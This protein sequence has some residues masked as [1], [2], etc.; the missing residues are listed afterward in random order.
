MRMVS[1]KSSLITLIFLLTITNAQEMI[2]QPSSGN[3]AVS[4]ASNYVWRGMKLSKKLATQPTVG[5][6]YGNFAVN[7]WT[8][9]DNHLNETTETDFTISYG[10]TQGIASMVLGYI[11]YG[12][13]GIADTQEL[14]FTSSIAVILNPA[15]AVY[16]DINE[17]KGEFIV[18][19]IGHS[20]PVMQLYTLDLGLSASFNLNNAI[21]GLNA[22]GDYFSNFYNGELSAS[23]SI[24]LYQAISINPLLAYSFPLSNDAKTAIEALSYDNVSNIFYGSLTFS[25]DF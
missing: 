10:L 15:V 16:W 20:L 14:F 1:W 18:A 12:L 6:S 24:P 4:F 3:A 13:D 21:M 23:I 22:A 11:N 7:L 25:L 9:Y 5:I 8:N 19:S 2:T 17:G